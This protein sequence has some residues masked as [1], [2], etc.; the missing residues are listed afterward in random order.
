[1]NVS[2]DRGSFHLNRLM[3]KRWAARIEEAQKILEYSIR[4][5]LYCRVPYGAD[6]ADGNAERMSCH[7]CHVPLGYLHV[8]GCDAE[9]CPACGR[10]AI[11]CG[12]AD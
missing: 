3:T 7:D 12:C 10:Q 2:W 4:G 1:M 5:I 11:G 6:D 8:P 9:R